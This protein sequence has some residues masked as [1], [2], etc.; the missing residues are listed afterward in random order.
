MKIF[1]LPPKENWICDRLTS[2]WNSFFPEYSTKN[3]NEAD[4]IWLLADWCWNHL[5]YEILKN[6]KI[7]A[8][9][10]HIVPDKFNQMEL[11]NFM[12]RDQFIDCYHVP[13]IH[14]EKLL[15]QLTK[16]RIETIP[17]WLNNKLWYPED[18]DSARKELGIKKEE[19]VIGSFQRDTEGSDLVSPKLEKGPDIF[20]NYIIKNI[21]KLSLNGS[22]HVLLGAWRRQYVI[23]RLEKENIKYTFIE[24][25]SL[26]TLRKMYASCDLYIVSSRY[27]GGPQALIEAPAMKIPIISTNVGIANNVLNKNCIIDMKNEYYMPNKEDVDYSLKKVSDLSIEKI[28]K[29]FIQLFKEIK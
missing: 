6:K 11:K 18:K 14:T 22:I 23:N 2:E 26:E 9:V 25:A 19:F 20:C 24:N 15:R 5:P 17:Y 21:D 13:N 8:T 28:G 29:K 16:K 27:E 7:I 1:V 3:P 10:H 4:V 12:I